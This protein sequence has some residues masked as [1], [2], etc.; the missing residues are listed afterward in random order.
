[1][2][3]TCNWIDLGLVTS[4]NK[5]SSLVLKPCKFVKEISEEV[6]FI[7]VQ[8]IA[9]QIDIYW[10]L[11]LVPNS[12]STETVSIENYEIQIFKSVFMHIQ[13]YLYKISFLTTLDIYK[14]YFKDRL[15]WCKVIIHAY[16][17]RRQFALVHHLSCRSYCVFALRVL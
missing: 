12:Y 7:K 14:D 9:R 10:H 8:Q 15:T 11:M 3:F 6:L 17:N 13:V 16:S 5:N 2:H 1:M 4:R